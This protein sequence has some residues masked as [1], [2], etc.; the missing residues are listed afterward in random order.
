MTQSTKTERHQVE[1]MPLEFAFHVHH[2]S[3]LLEVLMEPIEKRIAYIKAYKPANEVATRLR[4]LKK[5]QGQLPP[6]F[7]AATLKGFA[8]REKGFALWEKDNALWKKACALWN[9]ALREEGNALREKGKALREKGNALREKGNALREKAY[10]DHLP[11]IE[12]LHELEC[13][14]CPWDGLSIFPEKVKP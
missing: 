10:T 5:V 14:N 3:Y 7:V 12:A 13:P 11:E 2:E 8:L 6:A 9:N 1:D 4:L